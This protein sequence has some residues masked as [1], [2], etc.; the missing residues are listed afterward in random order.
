MAQ[1]KGFNGSFIIFI[2]PD[3]TPESK[4]FFVP[5]KMFISNF[6]ISIS[7]LGECHYIAEQYTLN[8]FFYTEPGIS[9]DN[10]PKVSCQIGIGNREARKSHRNAILQF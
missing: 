3:L 4:Y 10:R 1:F 6:I 5:T 2:I 7:S 9:I 8:N